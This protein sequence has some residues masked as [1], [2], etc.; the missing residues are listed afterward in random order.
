MAEFCSEAGID[1]DAC[2]YHYR[3]IVVTDG[4]V[5]ENIITTARDFDCDLIVMGVKEWFLSH[6]A[7]GT[8]TKSVMGQVKIPVA[9]VPP[10]EQPRAD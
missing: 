1:D 5:V 2:G 10:S 3:E 4:D 6:N 8:T 7:I 9:V